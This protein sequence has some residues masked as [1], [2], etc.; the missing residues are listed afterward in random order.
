[1]SKIK[2]PV[3]ICTFVLLFSSA[4]FPAL[5]TCYAQSQ[6]NENE[7]FLVAQKAFEDGFYDVAMRYINQLFEQ[8]PQTS[9]HIQAKLL[10][11]QCYFFK[12][13]YLKAYDTFQGLL[14]HSEFKD[15]TLFWLGE[16]Y[17]KGSDHKQAEKQYRQLI[18]LYP[19]SIYAPQSYYSLGWS[20]FEQGEF[21]KAKGP[22]LKLM[23]QFPSH[24]LREDASF[25][26]AECE[27]NLRAY[28]NAIQYFKN[29]ILNFP[30]SR[31]HPE[32][33][34]YIAEAYYYLEDFLT[35]VTYYAKTAEIAYD[36]KLILLAKVSLGWS[37]LKLEKFALAKQNFDEAYSFALEKGIL[38]DDVFLGQATFYAETGEQE[39]ALEAYQ[40]LIAKFPDSERVV[41]AYLG[42]A[43]TYYQTKQYQE[44]IGAYQ[45]ILE[46]SAQSPINPEIQEKTYFG[47]AWAHLKAGDIDSA[48]KN[49]ETVK[50][51]TES[52]TV[53]ISAMTQIGDA[54]QDVGKFTKAVEVYDHI[55]KNFPDSPYTDY[56]QYRQ[57]I[58]LLKMEKIEAATLSFQSLKANFP[59]SKYINDTNYYLAVAY[60]KKEEWAVAAE[61]INDFIEGLP[62]A[63]EFLAEAHYILG[64]SNFNLKKYQDAWKTFQ[65]ILTD[66][67]QDLALVRNAEFYIAKCDY[68]TGHVPEAIK[69]FQALTA[70]YPKS[71]VAQEALMWLAD[72]YLEASDFDNAISYYNQF[73]AEFPGSD[74]IDLIY[75]ELG[76]AYQAKTQFD[77]AVNAF[78]LVSEQKNPEVHAKAKLA[79]ADIFS[80]DLDPDSTVETYQ[81]IVDTSPKFKRDA[82][83]KIAEVHKKTGNYTQAIA[84]YQNALASDATSSERTNAELQFLIADAYQLSNQSDQAVEE[85]LK[86]SYLY[87]DDASWTIKAYLRM[88]RIFEDNEQWDEAKIAYEK[89]LK[90]ETDEAKF[91][92]ERLDWIREHITQR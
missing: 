41:D 29:Y 86:I 14:Q 52:R 89:T 64:L 5:H 20:Q 58:A 67:P 84:A 11:G 63:N 71:K 70:K 27:Y 50:N 28:E 60:F 79:L 72:H 81:K 61:Y 88:A 65:T 54:Y 75:Y 83:V 37:Y 3:I 47:L 57:G 82:Y 78:K 33:Y 17:L 25:K 38:S 22:F 85:Y 4:Q 45:T 2:F 10:L 21:E 74:E 35:A 55:L 40:Q 13:Q 26:I 8:Y 73:I 66:Y 44:A 53:K 80:R 16:T 30:K 49:F 76:R 48:V 32:A 43:N 59:T 39:K 90:F 69:K 24:E 18:E 68:K 77:Q 92:Q 1:M 15:A 56:V 87:P 34:F 23:R 6:N 7:L 62:R 12:S 91:A 19:D 51:K 31:R 42:L 9:K 36:N 46:R